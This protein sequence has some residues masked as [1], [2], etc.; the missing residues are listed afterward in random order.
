[1]NSFSVDRDLVAFGAIHRLGRAHLNVP[2]GASS[3]RGRLERGARV[4]DCC[5]FLG[6]C[7]A[8]CLLWRDE[9][10]M[11]GGCVLFVPPGA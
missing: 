7:T 10:F 2:V 11:W 3:L 6:F 1:M 9:P 5:G 8:L 4:T